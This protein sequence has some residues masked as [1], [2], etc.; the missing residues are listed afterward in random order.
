MSI[1]MAY[2]L[3]LTREKTYF[4]VL[5]LREG[6]VC[7]Q[8]QATPKERAEVL[9]WGAILLCPSSATV[10]WVL[11]RAI[12]PPPVQPLYPCGLFVA[13]WS[14]ISYEGIIGCKA[15]LAAYAPSFDPPAT[16][17]MCNG[18]HVLLRREWGDISCQGCEEYG[19]DSRLEFPDGDIGLS[20]FCTGRVKLTFRPG[21][22]VPWA[23]YEAA[24]HRFR[25]D[26]YRSTEARQLDFDG[27]CIQS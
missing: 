26:R 24:P 11:P 20:F 19:F 7:Y 18:E 23:E 21:D 16:F 13:G 27:A 9:T 22:L 25:F 12:L 5:D 15:R 1:P 4:S 8:V 14:K 17:L 10:P 2:S 3:D 6:L